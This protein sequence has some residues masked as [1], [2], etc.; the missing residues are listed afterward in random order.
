MATMLK[1]ANAS[2][3]WGDQP[4]AAARLVAEQPDIDYLTLDYLAEVSL[5]IMA[6]MR[7][8]DPGSGYARDFL[9]ALGSLCPFWSAGG[10]TKVVTNAGGLDPEACARACAEVLRSA[11]LGRLRVAAVTGDDVL[12]VLK[13]DPGGFANLETGSPLSAVAPRLVT[14]NAYLGAGVIADALRAGADIV[15]TGRVADPSLTVGPCI[16][17]FG[18][19]PA[20]HDR[21]AGATVAGHLIECGTQACGGF[22]TDWLDLPDNQSIGFPIAEV[23]GDGTCVVTKPAGSGGAVT[24]Q[25][26]KEQLLYEVGD[27]GS[28]L[29]PDATV[30]FLTLRVEAA[31]ADRVR[32]RGAAGR[33]PSDSYKVSATYADGYKAHGMITV[34]GHDAVRKARRAGEGVLQR[35]QRAGCVYREHLIECLGTGASVRGIASRMS[36]THLVET[37]LRV[38]VAA[39][40]REPVERF[41]KEIAPLVT[42]GPQGVTGYASG[43]PRVQPIFGYW[44]TLVPR[45]AV[46]PSFRIQNGARP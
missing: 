13:S 40:A 26:V 8:R 35:L 23:S 33:A 20:D 3:F 12:A 16:A 46:A 41:A 31:G 9:D 32:V 7:A 36:D 4:E 19:S 6:M 34:F 27:P 10:R 45:S 2:G 14:A 25:T 44:P 1:I 17:E 22:S 15:V 39:D 11:N 18:W 37:V 29:S 30:S 21:I 5:S 38:S 42:C 24:V 43:R 28:Y